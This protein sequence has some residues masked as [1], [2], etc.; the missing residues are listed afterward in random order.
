MDDRHAAL[1]ILI[2]HAS[3]RIFGRRSDSEDEEES[4]AS[5]GRT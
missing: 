3:L 1:G 5:W 4:M 2:R